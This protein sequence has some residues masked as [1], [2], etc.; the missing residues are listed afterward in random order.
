MP[1]KRLSRW[2]RYVCEHPMT[3]LVGAGA[4]A[5]ALYVLAYP[6]V[7][8]RYPPLTD[9]PFHAAQTSILR[10]YWDPSYHFHEQYTLHPIEVPY[11][12]M[13][14]IG[15]LCSLVL[16][17]TSATKIMALVMLGLLPAG[18]AVLFWGMRK[19]PLWGLTGLVFV[20][21]NLSYWGFLNYVGAIGLYAMSIGLALRALDVPS[22]KRSIALGVCI[23]AV[24]FTHIYRVPFTLLSVAGTAVV[25]YPATRR[26]RPVVGPLAWGSALL[27]LYAI[28]RPKDDTIGKLD[29]SLH[30]ER[31]KEAQQHLWKNYAGSAGVSEAARVDAVWS[32]II[33]ALVVACVMFWWQGR[34]SGRSARE[35]WWGFGVTFLPLLF[36]AGY[37]ITFLTLPMRIGAWWYVYPREITSCLFILLGVLPDMPRQWP[38]RLAFVAGLGLFTTRYGLFVAQE[39]HDFDEATRDFQQVAQRIPQA[40]RLLYLVFDHS[41]S[42]KRNT[43]FIHLPAWIQAEKGGW[44]SFHMVAFGASPIRYRT[45]TDSSLYDGRGVIPPSVP[46]RWEWTPQR[47]RLQQ[48]GAFFDWFLVR[49][50]HDPSRLFAADPHIRLVSHDGTWWLFQREKAQPPSQ[51]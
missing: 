45:D 39:F 2:W 25:M 4:L 19:S 48:H 16:P 10:H 28:V 13:Y 35:R 6:L 15:A 40:P 3:S 36:A 30:T 50:R 1:G 49:Q 8:T 20:W 9:L 24:F 38:Y 34:L 7:V 22:R 33:V 46:D 41:G 21:S 18:L 27:G 17:I 14:L 26:I 42:S 47:F 31:L 29:F 37:L 23:T 11:I 12:S 5:L 43:P 51:Q 32:A 44:L